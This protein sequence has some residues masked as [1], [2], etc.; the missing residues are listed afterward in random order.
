[1]PAAAPA[2]L[3][4]ITLVSLNVALPTV[5]GT[6]RGSPV[7][8]AIAKQPVGGAGTTWLGTT[9][10]A[11]DAQADL[12]VHGG[13]D[14]AV[15]AYPSE[16]LGPW[17][18]ELGIAL[19]PASFGE[20]LT[21]AGALEDDVVVGDVWRWGEALVQPCQPRSPCYKLALRLGRPE[22]ARSLSAT[23][24]TGWYLRVLRPG[25]VP[26][27]GPLELVERP[28]HGVTVFEA[29][30][31]AFASPAG[32]DMLRRVLAAQELAPEWRWRVERRL[33]GHR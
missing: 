20:N 9:N 19:G 14:K 22:I 17:S 26:V 32:Y 2:P 27:A 15:Y 13:P 24:R 28:A 29:N 3:R 12:R 7:V 31:A 1:V 18:E 6:R 33:A 21:T 11:G 16:H 10:L 30:A 25:A 23:G 8:S 4:T 5:I